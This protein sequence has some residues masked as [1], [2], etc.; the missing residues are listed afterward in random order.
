MLAGTAPFVF[1]GAFI[2]SNPSPGASAAAI[3]AS[4]AAAIAEELFFRRLV[5]GWLHKWGA[6]VAVVGS[7]ALFAV[8]HLPVYG[9]AVLPLDFAAGLIFSWQR[10]ATGGWTAPAV[11]HCFANL[12]A[13]V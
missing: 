4:L 13:S 11:T 12:V 5:F 1:A 2:T 8:V 9:P 7:A 3:A 10:H 6:M